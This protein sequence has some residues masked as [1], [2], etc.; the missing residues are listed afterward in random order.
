M[1]IMIEVKP[2]FA[3]C[4]RSRALPL[5]L[6]LFPLLRRTRFF[7]Y[8]NFFSLLVVFFA[9][10]FCCY[11][12]VLKRD[13]ACTRSTEHEHRSRALRRMNE[14]SEQKKPFSVEPASAHANPSLFS[15]SLIRGR[16]VLQQCLLN[17][18]LSFIRL[19]V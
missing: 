16:R 10:L 14:K 15:L 19:T 17:A 6:L 7:A 3:I 12:C 11:E 9:R 13:V 1:I 2:L 4:R 5:T 18:L 8:F